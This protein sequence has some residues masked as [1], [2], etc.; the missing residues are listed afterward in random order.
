MASTV[1]Q[2]LCRLP[3]QPR[4]TIDPKTSVSNKTNTAS[5]QRILR[6]VYHDSE[7]PSFAL[8]MSAATTGFGP[9]HEEDTVLLNNRCDISQLLEEYIYCE[10][11]VRRFY[12]R[13]L[14]LALMVA[15]QPVGA[16][17]L[18]EAGP[19]QGTTTN[20]VDSSFL[21][22]DHPLMIAELK[23]PYRISAEDWADALND[24]LLARNQLS[25]EFRM[26][27]QYC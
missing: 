11:D 26:W 23:R 12:D 25:R 13:Y 20:T 24:G 6:Y 16:V 10:G 27:V 2:Q 18:S 1:I 15:L 19:S 7:A 14:T 21:F 5:F 17:Q 22:L 9:E 8:D 3:R 4:Y